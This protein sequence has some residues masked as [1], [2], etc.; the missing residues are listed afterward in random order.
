[1]SPTYARDKQGGRTPD[2]LTI[3][4][5]VGGGGGEEAWTLRWVVRL[6]ERGR[7]HA[8]A[9]RALV[10]DAECL[11]D[12]RDIEPSWIDDPTDGRAHVDAGGLLR[13]TLERDAQ[14]R[15][16]VVYAQTSLLASHGARAGEVGA[17]TCGRLAAP[18][19]A[20]AIA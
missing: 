7:A 16:A 4:W 6:D 3:E 8:R 15:W 11:V 1:M 10:G 18:T 17:P 19:H 13:A 9:E 2:E 14:G 12:A 20:R 5:R